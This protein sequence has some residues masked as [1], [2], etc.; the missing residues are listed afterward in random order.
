MTIPMLS[1]PK[2]NCHVQDIGQG[3]SFR[4]TPCKKSFYQR[5]TS[6]GNPIEAEILNLQKDSLE[7]V[8]TLLKKLKSFKLLL[9]S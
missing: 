1:P 9:R 7:K 8:S 2:I 4:E 6:F 5:E 3:V